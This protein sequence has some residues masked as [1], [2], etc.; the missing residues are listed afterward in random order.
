MMEFEDL[1]ELIQILKETDI[2]E[3]EIDQEGRRIKLKREST[4][5]SSEEDKKQSLQ[6]TGT[7]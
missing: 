3:I 4:A 2:V 6:H 1:K 5:A 7:K